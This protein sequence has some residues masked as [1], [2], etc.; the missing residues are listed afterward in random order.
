MRAIRQ[1]TFGAPETL[2]YEETP[3]PNPADDEVRVAVEAAGVH[4]VDTTIRKGQAGGPYPP[5]S[6]PTIPGREVAG[7]VDAAGPG[8]E[9]LW[10]GQR[11]VV[12]LGAAGGGY[13][14]FAV[15]PQGSLH[16]IP[17]GLDAQAAVAM[18]GTGRTA[19]GILDAAAIRA[20]DVVLVTAAAGGLGLL[21][22][23]AAK[24]AGATVIGV[25]GGEPKAARVRALGADYA[26]DY[27]ADDWPQRVRN[28]VSG[29][30]LVLD[31]VGG[32]V[33]RAALELLSPRGRTVMYGWSSGEPTHVTADDLY[34]L[35]ISAVAAVGPRMLAYPGGMRALEE[36]ALKQ[37]A[38]GHL[39]PTIQAYPLGQAAEAHRALEQ[40]ETSGKVVLVP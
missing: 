35:G 5:P 31:G 33:G 7:A 10:P 29:V 17:E 9:G 39:Q 28:V 27:L 19:V 22:S 14:E 30:T 11:V 36:Q 26:F 4:L 32:C 38:A 13:A 20:D 18:I 40:R 16:L 2:K 21:L 34:S 8:V 1:Y 23:G 12:H 6:L 37:A 25:T 24:R 15:A 3:D